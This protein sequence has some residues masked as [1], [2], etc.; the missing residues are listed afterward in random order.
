MPRPKKGET[1]KEFIKRY[2]G[3]A[4][5]ANKYPNPDQ[6][7]AVAN[8]VWEDAKGRGKGSGRKKPSQAERGKKLR[9]KRKRRRGK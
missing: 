2:M 7:Y 1:K 6:R 4:E 8:S 3:S 5:A 9:K